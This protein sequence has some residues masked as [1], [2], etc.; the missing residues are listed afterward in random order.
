MIALHTLR[1][2]IIIVG[3]AACLPVFALDS[4][5]SLDAALIDTSAAA[6]HDILT[7]E[8]FEAAPRFQSPGVRVILP[9]PGMDKRLFGILPNHRAEAFQEHY[10]PLTRRE[11]FNI[12][13]SDSFDWPNYFMLAGYAVQS[14]VASGGFRKN[15]GMTGFAKFYG[16]SV[17]DQIIGSYVTEAILP[18]L[19]HEDPR[20]FRIGTGS[21]L[22]RAAYASSR[23]L[24]VRTDSGRWRFNFS[25]ILGNSGVIA[26]TSAYYP[27]SQTARKGA[28]RLSMTLGNDMVSNLLT[29][30]W[31]DIKRR[32]PF[33]KKQL[34]VREPETPVRTAD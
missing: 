3:L 28:Q 26:A 4:P 19:L 11:K 27:E 16:R 31:P 30:F 14:Q 18:S 33:H 15:G 22:R 7:L 8:P 29:E 6:C 34:A 17:S 9:F 23:V 5:V 20:F 21:V 2:C 12:A 13:K 32:L 10:T 24:I 1:T 25:E